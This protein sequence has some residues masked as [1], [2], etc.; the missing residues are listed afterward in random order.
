MSA[1]RGP[2]DPSAKNIWCDA[3]DHARPR[4][5]LEQNIF[6]KR[7]VQVESGTGY[8]LE[9]SDPDHL[10]DFFALSRGEAWRSTVY[11]DRVGHKRQ[12]EQPDRGA[13]HG[14]T[15]EGADPVILCVELS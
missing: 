10:Q 11:E 12:R 1:G 5:Y 3:K 14:S 13:S 8:G 4:K 9:A 7:G 6:S 15:P 2:A